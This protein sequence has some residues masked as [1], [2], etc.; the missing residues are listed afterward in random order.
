MHIIIETVPLLT[1]PS[2]FYS[3]I[4]F[5]TSNDFRLGTINPN[6]KLN[7]YLSMILC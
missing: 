5:F 1:S 4:T 3:E 2:L 6:F 7:F